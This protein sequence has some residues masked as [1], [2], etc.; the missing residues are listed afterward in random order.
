MNYGQIEDVIE[1]LCL[2]RGFSIQKTLEKGLFLDAEDMHF[3]VWKCAYEI[4]DGLVY[5]RAIFEEEENGCH[6][7]FGYSNSAMGISSREIVITLL[8]EEALRES[9]DIMV[10]VPLYYIIHYSWSFETWHNDLLLYL[11]KSLNKEM[12]LSRASEILKTEMYAVRAKP[13]AR[14]DF[15]YA[16]LWD[17]AQEDVRRFDA[18]KELSV[19]R[20]ALE[21]SFELL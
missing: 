11:H 18:W 19:M 20:R 16:N 1:E 5:F 9:L 8:R 2:A 14:A 7:R 3:R 4:E 17:A 6:F 10:Q 15:F 21:G 13:V 12:F